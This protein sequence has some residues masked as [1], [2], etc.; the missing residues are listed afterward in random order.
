M[1][2]VTLRT[3]FRTILARLQHFLWRDGSLETCLAQPLVYKAV[4][5]LLLV[6]VLSDSKLSLKAAHETVG[7]TVTRHHFKT[8]GTL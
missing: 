2:I 7:K 6:S 3:I 8:V 1:R 4:E 5:Q